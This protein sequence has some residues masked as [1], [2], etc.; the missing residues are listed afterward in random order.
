MRGVSQTIVTSHARAT[1]GVI[2]SDY[3]KREHAYWPTSH[4]ARKTKSTSSLEFLNYCKWYQGDFDHITEPNH[5]QLCSNTRGHLAKS[6]K[7]ERKCT[8]TLHATRL[9]QTRR[10]FF[11]L[12]LCVI[13]WFLI[14]FNTPCREIISTICLY[15]RNGKFDHLQKLSELLLVLIVRKELCLWIRY[16]QLIYLFD[17]LL[18]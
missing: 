1:C 18:F 2:V 15:C 16:Y 6:I 7:H 11:P 5:M 8:A 10:W 3:S 14:C 13:S 4:F 9:G 12:Y 17:G